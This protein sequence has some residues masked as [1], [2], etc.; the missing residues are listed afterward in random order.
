[1]NRK[2]LRI[3]FYLFSLIG[4]IFFSTLNNPPIFGKTK[5]LFLNTFSSS[6]EFSEQLEKELKLE[7]KVISDPITE[8]FLFGAYG[9]DVKE[10]YRDL[11]P[12]MNFSLSLEDLISKSSEDN[13]DCLV[14]LKGFP[15]TWV[16]RLTGH[17]NPVISDTARFYE[18]NGFR[19]KKLAISLNNQLRG[20]CLL[21]SDK[22]L[23][24]D[25][26]EN[27]RF[28]S[29]NLNF[30][31]EPEG[32]QILQFKE[33]TSNKIRNILIDTGIQVADSDKLLDYLAINEIYSIDEIFLFP[34]HKSDYSG[35]WELIK[36]GI[37]IGKVWVY[38]PSKEICEE[39]RNPY[40]NNSDFVKMEKLLNEKKIELKS[41]TQMTRNEPIV[42]FNDKRNT[43]SIFFP[44]SKSVYEQ[45]SIVVN[46][47]I[48]R[49]ITNSRSYLF[50]NPFYKPVQLEQNLKSDIYTMPYSQEWIDFY[51]QFDLTG[52]KVGIIKSSIALWCNQSN[53]RLRNYFKTKRMNFY[54]SGHHGN[55][56]FRHFEDQTFKIK[57]ELE[58]R[59]I[60]SEKAS[61]FNWGNLFSN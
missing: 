39:N 4:I 54:F 9:L 47:P 16:P 40:C 31:Q 33:S 49:L 60:C 34:T 50:L 21:V 53:Y 51:E 18:H 57:T 48:L 23:T 44:L 38:R 11:N 30:N 27:F 58:P 55:I 17:W 29:P 61:R 8:N 59:Q 20:K 3:L 22:E 46:I 52:A 6:Y 2:Y 5:F 56:L 42:T 32:I 41:V 37:P 43:L 1:M 15:Q 7:K 24:W 26:G 28:H 13:T 10:K 12:Y 35:L 45:S 36:F 25:M 14:N 19:G